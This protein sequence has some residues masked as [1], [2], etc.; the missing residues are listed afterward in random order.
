MFDPEL[1]MYRWVCQDGP[2]EN[3]PEILPKDVFERLNGGIKHPWYFRTAAD[4]IH[5]A[6]QAALRSIE[7]RLEQRL[8]RMPKRSGGPNAFLVVYRRPA[9]PP[10]TRFSLDDT[11][12]LVIGIAAGA[13]D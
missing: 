6:D 2:G 12:D 10:P 11:P 3:S 9:S 4:A 13:A 7:E 5:A 8:S 1:R